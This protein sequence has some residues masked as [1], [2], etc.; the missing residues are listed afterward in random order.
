MLWNEEVRESVLQRLTGYRYTHTLGVERAARWLAQ[1]YG[2][3]EE[4]A[5]CAACFH[6][7]TKR[8]SQEEQLN[9]CR[10]YD[11]IPSDVEKEEWKMLHGK[12][13]AAIAQHEYGA[14][15][16]VTEAIACHTTGRG[17]MTALDKVLYMA[18]YI[19]ETR[20]F[21]G[22]ETARALAKKDIDEALLYCFDGSIRDLVER[23]KLI[24]GDTI[25]ARNSLIAL[26]TRRR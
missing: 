22:V 4:Q 5:A 16:V 17:S 20:S 8:L 23:C 18:D 1:K 2:A 25:E 12:T 9:L 24:H 26:G 21:D 7:I 11:I 10:K 6:D 13:A 15:H 3:D 14:P 19:E